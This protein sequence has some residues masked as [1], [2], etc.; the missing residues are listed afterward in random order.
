MT[1]LSI[2]TK[3][4]VKAYATNSKGTSY[5]AER[6]ITTINFNI[7]NSPALMTANING[8][9]FNFM[10]PYQYA[11]TGAD[12]HVYND[13][14]PSG[15]P[16]YLSMQGNTSNTIGSLT[17]IWLYIPNV[18][19]VPGTYSLIEKFNLEGSLLCQASMIL[20]YNSSG[21][22]VY[23]SVTGGSV[24]ITEFNLTTKRI[25][26]TFNITYQKS[27]SAGGGTFQITH[28]TFN[29][30]LDHSYFN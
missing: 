22:P 21:S 28:G 18:K 14:A 20:P 5:G 12:V 11:L 6:I 26:G 29:Y 2:N 30:G 27:L 23:S 13:G 15:D 19:W 24:T 7:D 10:Q 9:Q 8:T 16:R 17:Q 25:K 3:Y 1:G 4:Y